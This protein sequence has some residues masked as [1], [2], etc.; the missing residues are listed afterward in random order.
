[1]I[2]FY[3][4][5]CSLSFFMLFCISSVFAQQSVT[6][7]V[8]DASGSLSG[9][10]VSVKGTSKATQ[11]GATGAYTIQV[12]K[13][14]ILR[15]SML[16]YLQQEILVSGSN[17][18]NVKL[19]ADEKALGEVVVT[20]LGIKREK[21][22]LGYSAQKVDGNEIT[23]AAAPD[24]TSGLMGK[25]AGLNITSSNG[26]QGNSQRVVIR[27]NNNLTGNNQA[28]IVVDGI[29][30]ENSQLGGQ[31]SFGNVLDRA[32][33]LENQKDWG[34]FLNSLNSDDIKEI[35]VLKGATA[36]A[37]YGSRGANGVLLIT[38]KKGAEGTGL[39]IDYNFSTL[40]SD[41]YRYSDV[42]NSYGMGLASAMWK[43]NNTF[44]KT[45]GGQNR[46]PDPWV[47]MYADIPGGYQGYEL[48][49]WFGRAA[50]WGPKLDGSDILWWDG[51]VRKWE[52]QPDNRKAF[53]RVG[54]ISTHNAA[55][56]KS[57]DF[58][59][60]RF[61][62]TRLDNTAIVKNSDYQQNNFNLGS[63][64]NISDKIKAEV[65]AS[66]NNYTRKN[67]PDLGQDFSWGT[68]SVY[69]MSRDYKPLEFDMY[70]NPD[71]SK[72][73]LP[74]IG[75]ATGGYPYQNNYN[76]HLFWHLM[77]QNQYMTRNQ[78]LGTAKLSGDVTPW[79]NLTGRASIVDA[80]TSIES[81][82]TPVDAAG[83]QGQY[84]IETIKNQ[85]INFEA[86]GTLHKDNILGGDFS[87]SLMV[88]ASSTRSRMYDLSAW[89]SGEKD[90]TY[91]QSSNYPWVVGDKYYLANTSYP[92]LRSAPFEVWNNYNINSLF[93]IADLSYKNYLFLQVTG[94][95]D[96]SSTLPLINASYFYPSTSL[97]FVFTDAIKGLKSDFFNYGK[98]KT[99]YAF[100]ANG[101][102]AYQSSP[103]YQ[104]F[105]ISNYLN[106][107]APTTFGGLPVR[108]YEADLPP[109]SSLKPQ[110]N[111]S[112]EIGLELGFFQSRL[113]FELTYYS[114][115]SKDQILSSNLAGS[116]GATGITFNT[117]ELS[118]KGVEFTV[119]A[120]PIRSENFGWDIVLNGAHNKNKVIALSD[121]IDIFP[122]QD[123]W[124]N[125]G[126]R[127]YVKAGE[128]Y[129][130]I[131]GYDYTY[132]NGQKVVEPIYDKAN[133]TKVVGSK[134]TTTKDLVPIGNAMPKLTG[135]L[136]NTF[137]YKKMSLYFLTDFKLGGQIY[138]ADYAASM[139][140][141]LAPE[142]LT[143]RDGGGLPY[144]YPDGSTANHGV[145]L[146]GVYANG[147]PNKDVV[148][149]MYKYAGQYGA[150]SNV[151]MPR[152]NAIFTNSWIKL[153]ELRFSYALPGKLLDKTGFIQGLDVSL[154]GRNL[155]YI[156][157][158]LPNNLNPEAING[159]G[160]AQGIQWAQF[161]GTREYG[162]SVKVKF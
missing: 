49:S 51:Q 76:Q 158:S 78:F 136:S 143:E 4:K 144:T 135:G 108:S 40:F 74:A 121:G 80:N 48:F 32:K 91:G 98:L 130:T 75:A 22:A 25:A 14:Q 73:D 111:T 68:F 16:G 24:L 148:H 128:D 2:K 145:I 160:N 54:N 104:N 133:P 109:A 117:G 161:P 157:S 12:E 72:A 138:S 20:A 7:I 8:S 38:T 113:N 13:G 17:T 36:A 44:R 39:G 6:G 46:F 37:L 97:S 59:S 123:L 140:N 150:W 90:A 81:K 96:W 57:G 69:N 115:K 139:A 95:N 100:S 27:G 63:N 127:M 77:E 79:L 83:L 129:G 58:G 131:Y 64:I 154:I 89:N 50:S 155:F 28:L 147:Q 102:L 35:T 153:R 65:S 67:T 107:Q 122:L 71:G 132:V 70:K 61:A 52:P 110:S 10:S 156:Y 15:F 23:K 114:T 103:T 45:S 60:V 119:R 92:G 62:Y 112:Q 106:A 19:V 125:N 120:T 87:G 11:T 162:V 146:D 126:V 159:I 29:Q 134:Y 1:M 5:C 55:I 30:I 99:S 116:S 33:N 34:S 43:A 88:G 141:G 66:Y 86:F 56:S 82:Y 118:N 105:I 47:D 94:R 42:Q 3:L 21:R 151:A 26:I 149:Y 152:S 93:G 101:A 85:D 142:T 9:V 124:G 137:R 53:Y 18:I 41:P 31:Q 84:G